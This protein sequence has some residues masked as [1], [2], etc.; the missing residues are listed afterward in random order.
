MLNGDTFEK[1]RH[2]KHRYPKSK[3]QKS[4]ETK[5]SFA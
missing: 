1:P 5:P 3:K 4:I 2:N